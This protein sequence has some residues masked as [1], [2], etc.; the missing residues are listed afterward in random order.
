ML[1]SPLSSVPW[2]K[3]VILR[4]DLLTGELTVNQFAADLYEVLMQRGKT[5]IYENCDSF[6]SLTFPAANLRTLAGDVVQRL[7]GKNDKSIHQL[8]LTYGGGKTHTL[9]TLAHLVRDPDNLPDIPAVGEFK[10]AAGIPIPKSRVVAM[11][12]DKIDASDGLEVLAPNGVAKRFTYPWSILAWQIAGEEGIRE[13][14]LKHPYDERDTPPAEDPLI[15][16]LDPAK[17]DNMPLLILVDEVLMYA[18]TKSTLPNWREYLI[19][20]FQALTQAVSKTPKCCLVASLL[21]SNQEHNTPIGFS[22]VSEISNI[23]G[24][25]Q[26]GSIVSVTRDEV[27]EILRRRFFTPESIRDH[28]VFREHVQKVVANISTIDEYTKKHL[29][30]QE[31]LYGEY[32]PFHPELL[33]VFYSK[34]NSLPTFQRTRG[35]LRTFALALRDSVTWDTSPM[36]GA[37]I[38]L[39]AEENG[40][41][42]P[43][44]QELVAIADRAVNT[45]SAWGSILRT[46]LDRAVDAD[47]SF[48]LKHREVEQAVITVFL[49][50]QPIGMG[51]P[52]NK[53]LPLIGML[54]VQKIDLNKALRQWVD[55]SFWLDDNLTVNEGMPKEWKLGNKPNLNQMHNSQKKLLTLEEKA[56]RLQKAIY[57]EKYFTSGIDPCVVSHK[58]PSSP[59][60]VADDGK[61]HF[62]VLPPEGACDGDTPSAFAENFLK[63]TIHQG[64]PRIHSNA[65]VLLAPSKSGLDIAME[66]VADVIAWQKVKDELQQQSAATIDQS[67]LSTLGTLLNAANG[68]LSDAIKQAWCMAVTFDEKRTPKAFKLN[69]GSVTPFVAIKNDSRIR[70]QSSAINAESLLPGGPYNLWGQNDQYRP[71]KDILGTFTK[72]PNMPKMLSLDPILETL[73]VGCTDGIFVLRLPRPDGS[74]RTWWICPPDDKSM[75]DSSLEVWLPE[76]AKLETI[77]PSLILPDS[78]LPLWNDNNDEITVMTV[79]ELFS[80][81]KLITKQMNGY[82]EQIP[83][84]YANPDAVYRAI[85]ESVENG[86]LWF[87]N[88]TFSIYNEK[89]PKEAMSDSAKLRRPPLSINGFAVTPENLS[90]AWRESTSTVKIIGDALSQQKGIKLPWVIIKNAITSAINTKCIEIDPS[91]SPWPCDS[92]SSENV[93]V[94]IPST[95]FD[96]IITKKSSHFLSFTI[97][98]EKLFDLSETSKEIF[99][100]QANNSVNIKLNI[101]FELDTD[102]SKITED[103]K[104]DFIAIFSNFLN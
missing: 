38:F 56:E 68:K 76:T 41:L 23:F 53:L 88:D 61:F 36:I 82:E 45:A 100:W 47:E 95:I 11:C 85:E 20:F 39:P 5:P 10:A 17:R 52:V 58:L 55:T 29:R 22:L 81:N 44:T 74:C 30:E 70:V 104:N 72:L 9:I 13:I 60:N 16:L 75:R 99:N 59:A 83:V 102:V 1:A 6:F 94:K 90:D 98:P 87:L 103:A 48:G 33:D 25:Q 2:H 8:A 12:F 3:V 21:S 43:A 84:P 89:L 65:I 80:G 96:P 91:G 63:V 67:R 42:P 4:E 34:W 93:K 7:A 19:N 57:N 71:V 86:K 101:S 79:L 26:Q 18:V 32:Y 40:V 78:C 97:S 24:R 66:R 49:H 92:V 54:K 14:N 64:S 73:K 27:S 35:L 51:C 28:S 50:S 31:N 77:S 46:E 15:R 62:V 37:E 69:L